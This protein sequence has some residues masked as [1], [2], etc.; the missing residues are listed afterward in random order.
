MITTAFCVHFHDE[1]LLLRCG[2]IHSN[3]GPVH[4]TKNLS[5]CHSNIRS[6][7]SNEK[8]DHIRVDFGG[9]FDIITLSE[10]WLKSSFNND[11]LQV[12]GYCTPFRKDRASNRGYGGV[13]AWVKNDIF[14]KRLYEYELEDMEVMWLIVRSFNVK[15]ILGICYRPPNAYVDW[16]LNFENMLLNV[17]ESCPGHIMIT[18]D[19]NSNVGNVNYNKLKNISDSFNLKIHINE[20]T[21]ENGSI[22]DQ[23]MSNCEKHINEIIVEDPVSVNDHATIGLRLKF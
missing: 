19:F 12:N 3:P 16:W 9:R 6:I 21:H 14:C 7:N 22:L 20:P 17:R 11:K 18:G 13:L 2:D 23:F 8:L 5:I 15:L 10:T 1:L 4:T